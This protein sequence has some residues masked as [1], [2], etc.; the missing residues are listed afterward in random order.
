[1]RV[2]LSKTSL[3]LAGLA[4]CTAVSAVFWLAPSYE[5]L[6][7]AFQPSD[8]YVYDRNGQLMHVVRKDLHKRQ[9][10]WLSLD[11]VSTQ[12]LSLLL[13]A[14]DR[15]FYWHPGVDPLASLRAGWLAMSGNVRGGASTISMQ[16]IYLLDPTLRAKNARNRWLTKI[17]QGIK[18]TALDARWSKADIL[19]AYINLVPFRGEIEGLN[20]AAQMLFGKSAL[21]IN[22][23]EAALLVAMIRAPNA[24]AALIAKRACKL[25]KETDCSAVTQIIDIALMRGFPSPPRPSHAPHATRQLLR[26]MPESIRRVTTTLDLNVQ[27]EVQQIIQDKITSI[28]ERNAKDAAAIVVDNLSGDVIAYVGSSDE[29][30]SAPFVDGAIAMRQAGST[31]K[32]FIY[33]LAI[34][35]KILTAA[36]ILDDSPTEM[37]VTAG[38]V[39]RPQNYDEK[40]R[41]AVTVRDALAGSLNIPAVR[42]LLMVGVDNIIAF[43]AT[44][45]FNHLREAEYYGP[46]LALGSADV[47]LWELAGAYRALATGGLYAPIGFRPERRQPAQRILS[48]NAAFIIRSILSDNLA[49]AP[50][51]GL[52][53]NLVTSIATA[54]K[55]GT[56]KDMRDNWCIGFSPTYTV[57]VWVGNFSGAPMWN[58]TGVSGAAPIWSDIMHTLHRNKRSVFPPPPAG[59]IE[60]TIRLSYKTRTQEE[61]FIRGTEPLSELITDQGGNYDYRISYPTN[62]AVF[63]I[64]YD[65]PAH[66][67]KM[68]FKTSAKNTNLNWELNG[69]VIAP[70]SDEV[71]WPLRRGSFKLALTDVTGRSFDQV[72]FTVK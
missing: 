34:E 7:L 33:G 72:R 16:L 65:I 60:K 69:K 45:G 30:S 47:S 54:A 61:W 43:L 25:L 41:G 4:L 10:S 44:A 21:A 36:S 57:A 70:A 66:N 13:A 15:R 14:E 11:Q 68:M 28:T 50:S 62:E 67:Q 1:M 12:F 39:Y 20:A 46:S 48:Q 31:L 55:T 42:T 19:T 64:D 2:W 22:R 63:A 26:D 24:N 51:F 71:L 17:R 58:L 23:D 37:V 8:V 18:A 49:R 6:R 40:F 29:L 56:S 9:F 53:N 3:L 32:P 27:R 52:Q 59:L 5:Q 35:K 38:G